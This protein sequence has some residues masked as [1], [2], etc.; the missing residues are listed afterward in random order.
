MARVKSGTTTKR[1]H[2]KILKLAKGFRGG[3]SKLYRTAKNAVIKSLTY[4]YRDRRQRKRD[5]RKLWIIRINAATREHGL[6]Y[7]QFMCG[8]HKA[9]VVLDRRV[10]ANLAIED[11]A[12]FAQLVETA[13]AALGNSVEEA[14]AA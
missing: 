12:A 4:A 3:R 8:L 10:L 2:K 5:F 11:S 14:Q 7:S 1:R 13:K 6:S 9:N